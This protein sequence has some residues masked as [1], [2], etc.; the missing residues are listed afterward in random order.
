ME[1]PFYMT[2]IVKFMAC[3][4][5]STDDLADYLFEDEEVYS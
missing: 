5:L 2:D 3:F 1:L 4:N